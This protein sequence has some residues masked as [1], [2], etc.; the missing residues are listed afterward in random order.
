MTGE[1]K[2]RQALFS[3]NTGTEMTSTEDEAFLTFNKDQYKRQPPRQQGERGL[4]T[5]RAQRTEDATRCLLS[6]DDLFEWRGAQL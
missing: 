2:I 3:S 1:G 5:C 4:D 6:T